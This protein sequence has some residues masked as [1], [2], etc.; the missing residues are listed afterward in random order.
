[1]LRFQLDHTTPTSVVFRHPQLGGGCLTP[2][3]VIMTLLVGAAAAM[4]GA[5]GRWGLWPEASFA[6]A[7]IGL[8]G[9]SLVLSNARL[10]DGHT[11]RF[12]AIRGVATLAA[13]SADEQLQWPLAHFRDVKRD[14]RVRST[15]H[16]DDQRQTFFLLWAQHRDGTVLPLMETGDFAQREQVAEQLLAMFREAAAQPLPPVHLPAL[17]ADIVITH[18]GHDVLVQWMSFKTASE[19]VGSVALTLLLGVLSAS[20]ALVVVEAAVVAVIALFPMLGA[21]WWMVR[22]LSMHGQQ[23]RIRLA[24]NAVQYETGNTGRMRQQWSVAPA[25]VTALQVAATAEAID[26][27][28]STASDGAPTNQAAFGAPLYRVRLGHRPLAHHVL[29]EHAI[30]RAMQAR[31]GREVL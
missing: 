12:D 8:I 29:L 14:S 13:D 1:M 25:R 5:A 30:Q 2:Y 9:L 24:D 7:V 26:F 27:S 16:D 11:L 15:G 23:H 3:L 6:L 19:R 28:I 18:E 31:Y 10:R 17:P 22:V 4:L 21:L 20:A